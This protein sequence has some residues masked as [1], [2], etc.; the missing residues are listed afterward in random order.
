MNNGLWKKQ[1]PEH[2]LMV[3]TWN[4]RTMGKVR[5]MD[6]I[7]G[8]MMEYKIDILAIQKIH[9]ASNGMIDL[10][11]F[12][13]RASYSVIYSGPEQQTGLFGTRFMI[14]KRIRDIALYSTKLKMREYA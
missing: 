6:E 13:Y 5:E 4:V 3:A 7:A 14:S 12:V 11:I 10:Y 1:K 9:W 8:E 2:D